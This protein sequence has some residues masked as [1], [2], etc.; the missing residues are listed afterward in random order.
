[1]DRFCRAANAANEDRIALQVSLEEI[2][3]NVIVHGYNNTPGHVLV[4]SMQADD[5]SLTATVV[6]DARP[7]D[8]LAHPEVDTTLPGELRPIGGLG[9][10]FVK[11][12]GHPKYERRGNQNVLTVTRPVLK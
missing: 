6:D 1:M 12:F 10:H 5:V 7:Y 3:T 8:P 9:I 4:V 11:N 2:A